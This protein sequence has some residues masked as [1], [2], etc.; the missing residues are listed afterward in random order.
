MFKLYY[1][2]AI[3]TCQEKALKQINEFARLFLHYRK[4]DVKHPIEVYGA[5]FND[6]PIIPLDCSQVYKGVISAYDLR[7][8]R[9]C[10]ILLVVTD[11]KQFGAGTFQEL[12]YAR[13]LGI[14]TIL[15]V[16]GGEKLRNIFLETYPNKVIFS[17]K[18]L[19][20]ILIDITQ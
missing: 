3:D 6:S 7:K 10:D 8:I 17:M 5:G 2:S 1:A 14:Y 19:E 16:L 15:L 20:E 11:L 18:E 9:E 12:E 4:G 13:G